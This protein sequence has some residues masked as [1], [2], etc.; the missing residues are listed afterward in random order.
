MNGSVM[1]S[2]VQLL[3]IEFNLPLKQAEISRWRGAFVEMIGREYEL[4]HNHNNLQATDEGNSK[5]HYRYPTI[6]YRVKSG[7][8]AIVAINE[9]AQEFQ[10]LLAQKEWQLN[11]KGEDFDLQIMKFDRYEDQVHILDKKKA[12]LIRDL[13]ILNQDNYFRWQNTHRLVDRA[14]LLESILVGQILS[15]CKAIEY[16][17]PDRKLEVDLYEIHHIRKASLKQN[18]FLEFDLSFGANIELPAGVGIGK[19]VSLGK[20]ELLAG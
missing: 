14:L 18:Q 19:K 1:S 16:R 6:Q 13:I 4:F 12:Y 2:L 5:F 11:W 15:F 3:H 7:R 10:Q 9:A 8:A 17:I 20:G